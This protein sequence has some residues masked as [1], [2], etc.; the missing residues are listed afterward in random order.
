MK[1][2]YGLV[3]ESISC[4]KTLKETYEIYQILLRDMKTI[5][6]KSLKNHL[7]S[8]KFCHSIYLITAIESLLNDFDYVSNS[9]I[10]GYSNGF[11]EGMNNFIKI[12]KRIAFGYKS[13]FHFRNRILITLKLK[14]LFDM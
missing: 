12:L 1:T 3:D 2:E 6:I 7:E 9:L 14:E 13:F 5:N 8:F 4:D 10:Y 11:T